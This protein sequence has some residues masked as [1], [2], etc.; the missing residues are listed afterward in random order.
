MINWTLYDK[1]FE[2]AI[3]SGSYIGELTNMDA[4]AE[5]LVK[6]FPKWE[7]DCVLQV[8]KGK[9]KT[10]KNTNIYRVGWWKPV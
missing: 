3:E 9:I 4:I 5:E 7:K 6:T 2:V 1:K 8:T 10:L